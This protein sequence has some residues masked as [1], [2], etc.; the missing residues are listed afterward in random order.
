MGGVCKAYQVIRRSCRRQGAAVEI[1]WQEA[2]NRGRLLETDRICRRPREHGSAVKS[3]RFRTR[4][5]VAGENVDGVVVRVGPD[6]EFW[7]I[8]KV[9]AEVILVAVVGTRGIGAGGDS[10]ALCC[11]GER[12]VVLQLAYQPA[13]RQLV[14]QH[15]GIP[16]IRERWRAS[17]ELAQTAEARPER[18]DRRRPEP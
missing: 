2:R 10:N 1:G 17:S 12:G 4:K 6:A 14:I 13:P 11:L 5:A 15:D 18:V 7:I 16:A 3:T 8:R 9:C